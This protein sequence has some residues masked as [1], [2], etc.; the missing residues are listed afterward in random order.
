MNDQRLKQLF[1]ATKKEK[2]AE[3]SEGFDLL[4]MQQIRSNP[5]RAE[6]SIADLL[7]R[8]FPRLALAA[9]AVIALCVV[10]EFVS[11]APTLTDSA[12][13]LSVQELVE[14]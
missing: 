10:T 3:A 9:V 5:A 14:N 11:T 1:S 4:V 2:P 7:G 12:A 8:W 6:L 13:Q